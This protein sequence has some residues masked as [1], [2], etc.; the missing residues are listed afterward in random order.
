MGWDGIGWDR[1]GSA[2]VWQLGEPARPHTGGPINP[3]INLPGLRV[4]AGRQAGAHAGLC[5][6]VLAGAS[7][8]WCAAVWTAR[9]P[10]PCRRAALIVAPLH[11][12]QEYAAKAAWLA[13]IGVEG[14]ATASDLLLLYA[15]CT[16][17]VCCAILWGVLGMVIGMRAIMRTA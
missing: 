7:L 5:L 10:A 16:F 2:G 4:A 3:P 12:A 14:H 6:L 8:G 13:A 15:S 11:A 9:C 1:L 17:A